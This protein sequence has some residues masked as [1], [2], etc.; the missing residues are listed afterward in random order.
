MT[1]S[2]EKQ[3]DSLMP[4][5]FNFDATYGRLSQWEQCLIE[6]LDTASGNELKQIQQFLNRICF[7]RE[8]IKQLEKEFRK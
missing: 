8:R 4:T 6:K 1:F 5:F 2:F 7:E 3:G